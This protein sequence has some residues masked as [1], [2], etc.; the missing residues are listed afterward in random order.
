[1]TENE[2]IAGVKNYLLQKGRT[3]NKKVRISA[4]AE[5]RE[6]GVDIAVNLGNNRYFI[7]AKGSVKSD[8][9]PMKSQFNTNFRWAISQ[10]ILRITTDPTNYADIYAIAVPD[11]AIEKCKKL[12]HN[13]V[14]LKMLKIRLFGVFRTVEGELFA[15]E[16]LPKDIYD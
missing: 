8:G 1:M 3:E 15:K 4:D 2:V 10:I 5:K 12:T 14:A 7:E 13:N 11:S 16:Y 9:G 6:H